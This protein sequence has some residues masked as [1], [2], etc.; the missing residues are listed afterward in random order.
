MNRLG[1]L[2]NWILPR[3]IYLDPMV[4]TAYYEAVA[5][6]EATRPSARRPR[7]SWVRRAFPLPT[8]GV[9]YTA[10]ITPAATEAM[11]MLASSDSRR[12]QS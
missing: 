3:L 1:R 12:S 7:V 4:A 5:E 10:G 9:G 2:S 8:V 11:L 6:N